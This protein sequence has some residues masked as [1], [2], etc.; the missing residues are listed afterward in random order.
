M[1]GKYKGF[2]VN[3]AQVQDIAKKKIQRPQ[4]PRRGSRRPHH[5][6]H[7]PQHGHHRRR[8]ISP[9]GRRCDVPRALR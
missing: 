1:S 8:V 9:S 2:K 5:R 7:G 3:A 6:G 4:R